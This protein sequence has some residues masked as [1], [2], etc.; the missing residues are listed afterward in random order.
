MRHWPHTRRTH[1]AVRA[2]VRALCRRARA[3]R[4]SRRLRLAD[5]LRDIFGWGNVWIELQRHFLPDDGPRIRALTALAATLELG[6]VATGG[7]HYARPEHRALA[8]VL[9]CIR[10]KTTLEQAGTRL[11]P[12]G[13]Y[14]MRSPEEM[15]RCFREHPRAVHNTLAI[16]ERCQFRLGKLHNE[17]PDF[18]L[19][20]WGNCVFL[21]LQT[22]A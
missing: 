19:A 9:A 13:E 15:L 12:N 16:A 11:R 14:Y 21:S 20:C 1:R 6:L 5:A 10:Q 4:F 2:V 3:R 7:V 17:F 8:D 18:P 22:R